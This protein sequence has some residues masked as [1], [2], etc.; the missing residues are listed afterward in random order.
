LGDII[1]PGH[2]IYNPDITIK[3]DV[4]SARQR[5][6]E[7]GFCPGRKESDL[8]GHAHMYFLESARGKGRQIT[9]DGCRFLT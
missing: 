9:F 7:E 2:S 8:V 5:P 4:D 3:F 6:A 1:T